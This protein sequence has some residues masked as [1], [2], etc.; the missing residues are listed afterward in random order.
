MSAK[1]LNL[2]LLVAILLAITSSAF[3]DYRAE[4]VAF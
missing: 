3:A 1:K 4:L 2:G